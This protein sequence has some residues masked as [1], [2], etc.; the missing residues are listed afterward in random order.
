MVRNIQE[1]YHD[2]FLDFW[3]IGSVIKDLI[4]LGKIISLSEC[5]TV[6]QEIRG[7]VTGN[8]TQSHL[9]NT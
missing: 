7:C 2:N 6:W 1:I 8:P 4:D 5:R 9:L 3:E